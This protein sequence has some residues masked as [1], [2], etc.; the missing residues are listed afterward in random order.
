MLEI[1]VLKIIL[2]SKNRYEFENFEKEKNL[3]EDALRH[4]L[5]VRKA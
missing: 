1:K 3:F 5:R 2:S 4:K